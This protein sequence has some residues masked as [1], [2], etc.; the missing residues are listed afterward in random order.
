MRKDC[1][2]LIFKISLSYLPIR[3]Q[4]IGPAHGM[5][6]TA[7]A[8][9]AAFTARIVGSFS[10]TDNTVTITC[11]AWRIDWSKSGRRERSITRLAKIA[12][13][14]GLPSL[15]TNLQPEIFEQSI[16]HAVQVIVTVI[17]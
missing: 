10:S 1:A 7:S 11:T 8:S 12:S 6:E 2:G 14:L 5:F 16:R 4:P 13:S 9:D 17:S 3:T 15:F